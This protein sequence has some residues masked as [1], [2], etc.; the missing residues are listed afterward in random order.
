MQGIAVLHWKLRKKL[1]F[2]LEQH[3]KHQENS[4]CKK[5]NL[6]KL[7]NLDFWDEILWEHSFLSG[8]SKYAD[9]NSTSITCLT[10]IDSWNMAI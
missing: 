6:S 7:S 10:E 5:Y 4:I 8:N 9:I 2:F 1:E 3:L